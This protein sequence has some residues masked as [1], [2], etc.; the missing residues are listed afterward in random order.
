M[1]LIVYKKAYFNSNNFDSIIPSV[2]ISLLQEF[3]DVLLDDIPSGLPPLRGIEHHVD[4][5]PEASILNRPAYRSNPEEMKELQRQVD[6][7]MMKE[8]IRESMS[9]CVVPVVLMPKKN[10]EDVC[11]LSCRQQHNGKVSTSYS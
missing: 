7:L 1:I 4:L 5:V 6:E 3:D 8:Y 11:P 10:M 9:S 2:V